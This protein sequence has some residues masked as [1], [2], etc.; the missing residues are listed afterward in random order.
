MNILLF[1]PGLLFLLL[2]RF[3][4]LGC[5]PKL[6]ICALLQ[7]GPCS[8]WLEGKAG[9]PTGSGYWAALPAFQHPAWLSWGMEPSRWIYSGTST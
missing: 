4:L 2:Q 8:H 9:S 1:A 7:V 3:G 6:C 5:I